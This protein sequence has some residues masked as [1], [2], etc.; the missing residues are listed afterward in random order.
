MSVI[1]LTGSRFGRLVVL[2]RAEN[3]K[4]GRARWKVVCEC[5]QSKVVLAQSLRAGTTRS[6]GCL[7]KETGAVAGRRNRLKH[8]QSG[9][10]RGKK[11]SPA[12][13]SW[14]A[15]RQRCLQPNAERYPKYGGLGVTICERWQGKDGF[16][17]FLADLGERPAGTTLG[18]FG[19]TGNYE[20]ENVRWMTPAEQ[21]SNWRPD[22][23]LGGHHKKTITEQIAA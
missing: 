12:Y 6:C 2:S 11:P 21:V 7:P 10:Y 15:M 16:S 9:Y 23:N 22:R 19:D 5:G 8:G 3:D 20:P 4:Y 14:Q 18:R 13:M 1:D 17:N